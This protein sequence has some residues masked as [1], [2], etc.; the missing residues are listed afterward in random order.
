MRS[1]TALANKAYT[2]I[3]GSLG[4]GTSGSSP[5]ALSQL[6]AAGIGPSNTIAFDSS[7]FTCRKSGRVR[8]Q[9][10]ATIQSGGGTL[11]PL[12]TISIVIRR[13]DTT[14][15]GG[16]AATTV[17]T[18]A[19]GLYY[20]SYAFDDVGVALGVPHVWGLFVTIGNAH[21]ATLGAAAGAVLI[22]EL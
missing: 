16:G 21:T 17:E 4:Q 19:A 14:V 2:S 18:S 6:N 22:E 3:L 1:V 8:I 7:P 5:N 20:V 13:D 11:A 12:D 15:I 9:V 10:Y